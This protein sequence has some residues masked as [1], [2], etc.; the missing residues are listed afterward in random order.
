MPIHG[1]MLEGVPVTGEAP[2]HFQSS[3][4]V[5]MSKVLRP[6]NA[7]IVPPSIH[8]WGNSSQEKTLTLTSISKFFSS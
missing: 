2:R 3:A 7:Q 5:P 6:P 1:Q 8:H 4:E